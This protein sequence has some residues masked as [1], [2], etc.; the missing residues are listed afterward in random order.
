MDRTVYDKRTSWGTYVETST[1]IPNFHKRKAAGEK[2]PDN[3]YY[4]WREDGVSPLTNTYNGP[5]TE[6]DSHGRDSLR[7][8]LAKGYLQD[9]TGGNRVTMEPADLMHAICK[10]KLNQ[11]ARE[12]PVNLGV[13]LG[14]YRETAEL[15]LG[16]AK[17]IVPLAK[18]VKKFDF[19]LA[20]KTLTGRKNDR[21]S[22]AAKAAA[23][24]WLGWSYGVRPV[25][26]DVYGSM[27]KLSENRD[28]LYELH[29]VRASHRA[30]LS[31]V[32]YGS[33]KYYRSSIEAQARVTGKY[34]FYV[35]NPLLFE[36][37]RLGVLNP[38]SIGYELIPFSF[39]LDW[40][41]PIGGYLSGVVPPP[42]VHSVRGYTYLKASGLYVQSTDIPQGWH[43]WL[44]SKEVIKD[45][46]VFT[47][48]PDYTLVVPDLS[49][50][51][52]QIGSGLALLTQFLR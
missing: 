50:S 2:L 15:F 18:A 33:N 35:E 12:S 25:M 43:T 39:V 1:K 46:R 3:S 9:L 32:S 10:N 34:S 45:R 14:E 40:F 20:L 47:G 37:D 11:K 51:K 31:G 16:A 19:S 52:A 17:R 44:E 8:T 27:Q 13:S 42:G 21:A 5:R 6:R 28:E 36:L 7:S 49:L 26:S 22:D 41:I 38:V 48:F 29:T 23:D 30:N 4:W 24:A